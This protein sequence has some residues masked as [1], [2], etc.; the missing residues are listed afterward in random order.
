MGEKRRN[1][2]GLGFTKKTRRAILGENLQQEEKV[3]D[4]VACAA[5]ARKKKRIAEKGQQVE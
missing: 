5:V 1:K 3:D 4:R 2:A